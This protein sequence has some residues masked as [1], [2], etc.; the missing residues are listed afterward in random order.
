M[1]MKITLRRRVGRDAKGLR[2][3][4]LGWWLDGFLIGFMISTCGFAM[5]DSSRDAS[6]RS[7]SSSSSCSVASSGFE[8]I[9]SGESL[10]SSSESELESD[11]T[12]IC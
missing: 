1:K 9:I 5:G 4:F 6:C 12:A 10:S 7:G 8:E 11:I 3:S 2:G